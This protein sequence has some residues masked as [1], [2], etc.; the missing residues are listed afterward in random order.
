MKTEKVEK[1]FRF[2]NLSLARKLLYKGLRVFI[3]DGYRKPDRDF[4]EA[5]YETW[6]VVG[7]NENKLDFASPGIY[8]WNKDPLGRAAR[9]EDRIKEAIAAAKSTI[10][11]LERVKEYG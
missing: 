10:D 7:R 5:R 8:V 6:Y 11:N 4:P 1:G 2:R 3:V 9:K